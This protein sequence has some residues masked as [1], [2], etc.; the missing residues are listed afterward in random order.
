M[1]VG[2]DSITKHVEA[3]KVFICDSAGS[4]KYHLKSNCR[5]LEKCESE[6]LKITKDEATK[7][8]KSELCGYED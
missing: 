4:K 6:I 3:K 5:G 2:A 7:K 1:F 8:G